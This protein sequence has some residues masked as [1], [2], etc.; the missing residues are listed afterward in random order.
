MYVAAMVAGASAADDDMTAVAS[1]LAAVCD[2]IQEHRKSGTAICNAD[3]Y[4][5]IDD[6]AAAAEDEGRP[7]AGMRERRMDSACL[8]YEEVGD[9][10]DL[11]VGA[12]GV[13]VRA[14][15]RV[16]GEAVA[17]KSLHPECGHGGGLGRLLR[18]ACFMAACGGH[19]SLVT[20]RGVTRMTGITMEED[21]SLVMEYVGPNLLDVLQARGRPFPEADVRAIM[22]QLLAGA[23]EMHRNG[24]VHRDIKCENILVGHGGA[25]KICDFGTAKSMAERNPPD[26]IAGTMEYMAPEVLVKNTD[27]DMG[28]DAWSLGCVMAELLTGEL[29]FRGEDE[30][31]QLYDIFDVLGVPDERVWQ[32]L[33][34]RSWALAGEV[35]QWRARQQ[36]TQHRNRLREL[37]PD[38][39]LSYDGF[40]VLKGLLTCDPRR[41]MTAAAALRCPWFT[42]NV[43]DA[44]VPATAV[45][46]IDATAK[47]H[48]VHRPHNRFAG[49]AMSL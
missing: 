5:M 44:G 9:D 28:V 17:V 32:A 10:V 42:D 24:I 6:V 4:A 2:M 37:L 38:E 13:V 15:H 7:T 21:Y 39:L 48:F 35:R 12:F 41:R 25:V 8:S 33:R 29:L 31:D 26:V 40:E 11:G 27:H 45:S 49:R 3:V 14:R 46:M 47:R 18:E 1:R 19:P 30:T 20:L 22:R 34:P 36:Q 16:T 43:E 23:E